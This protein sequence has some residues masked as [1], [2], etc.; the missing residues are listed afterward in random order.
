MP[1]FIQVASAAN[2]I[3]PEIVADLSTVVGGGVTDV[4]LMFVALGVITLTLTVGKMGIAKV[5]GYFKLKA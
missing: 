5:K 3:T 2:P 4:L 1:V